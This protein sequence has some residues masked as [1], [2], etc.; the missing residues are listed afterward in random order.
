MDNVTDLRVDLRGLADRGFRFIKAP[1]K[2]LLNRQADLVAADIHPADL[3]D[4][5]QRFGIDLVAEK[6]ESETAVVDLLDQDV[7]F[8]Q[9]FLFS[10]PRPVRPEALQGVADRQD[11][12]AIEPGSDGTAPGPARG[13]AEPGKSPAEKSSRGLARL[14]RPVFAD[15]R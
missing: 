15:P 3:A 6:I 13:A 14:A 9:G 5:L 11:V 1:A 10:P 4:L 7:R 2:L 12:V 8:G